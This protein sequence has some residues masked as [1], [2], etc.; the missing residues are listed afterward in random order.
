M[1]KED[2]EIRQV[3]VSAVRKRKQKNKKQKKVHDVVG[4][5]RKKVHDVVGDVRKKKKSTATN[6]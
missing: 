5:V 2:M 1:D 3:M 6:S 4:D